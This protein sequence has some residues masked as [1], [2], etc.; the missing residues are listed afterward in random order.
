MSF[1]GW[2]NFLPS[3]KRPNGS[4]RLSFRWLGRAHQENWGS[5]GR[6]SR[7]GGKLAQ[8]ACAG[9]G[10]RSATQSLRKWLT[11]GTGRKSWRQIFGRWQT[12]HRLLPKTFCRSSRRTLARGMLMLRAG[13]GSSIQNQ[14]RELR[15]LRITLAYLYFLAECESSKAIRLSDDFQKGTFS[16]IPGLPRNLR[17]W[18]VKNGDISGG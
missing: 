10:R 7:I 13:S 6:W 14:S 18:P 1:I 2:T 4:R 17:L 16:A 9:E 11:I 12:D 15:S 5:C 8:T 3:F